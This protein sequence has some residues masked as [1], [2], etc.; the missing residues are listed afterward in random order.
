MVAV[1]VA[2]VVSVVA[3][4]AVVP[5]VPAVIMTFAMMAISV[6]AGWFFVW[7]VFFKFT[8]FR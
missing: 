8:I 7:R 4:V 5:I 1:L 6:L 3:I 2:A